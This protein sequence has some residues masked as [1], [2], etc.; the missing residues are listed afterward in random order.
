MGIHQHFFEQPH[1]RSQFEVNRDFQGIMG[2]LSV[3][4]AYRVESCL[5]V[6]DPGVRLV[7]V[8]DGSKVDKTCPMCLGLSNTC[9]C[10]RPNGR[11]KPYD[12]EI[13]PVD[14]DFPPPPIGWDSA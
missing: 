14:F 8:V 13:E 5:G 4:E 9:Y 1:R 12:Q 10:D 11:P 3:R 7:P 2:Q 6:F